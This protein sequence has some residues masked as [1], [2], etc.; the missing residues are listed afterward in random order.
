[1]T[2]PLLIGWF[3][4]V[5]GSGVGAFLIGRRYWEV[6]RD[7]HEFHD[8][9]GTR[10]IFGEPGNDH[11]QVA[12]RITA[13]MLTR[14]LTRLPGVRIFHG[15]ACPGSVFADIDH[16]VLCG[17]RLVLIESKSWLPGHYT[18]DSSGGLLRNGHR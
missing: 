11:D 14:Y 8:E 10:K 9:F 5:T 3:T 16:A 2:T 1:F 18:S 17:R 12:E 13:E 4:L 6:R 15:L 7:V